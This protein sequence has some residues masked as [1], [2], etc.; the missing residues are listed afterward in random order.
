[1]QIKNIDKIAKVTK[2]VT[3]AGEA[4]RDDFLACAIFLAV[5]KRT[6]A[7][8]PAVTRVVK[9]TQQ[10]LDDPTVAVI[11]VGG[12]HDPENMNFDHHQLERDADATCALKQVLEYLGL[13]EFANRIFTWLSVS[14]VLDAKGP[15]TAARMLGTSQGVLFSMVS[16]LEG[17]LL[18]QFRLGQLNEVTLAAFGEAL[19]RDY[20]DIESDYALLQLRAKVIDVNGVKAMLFLDEK[21]I[22]HTA[23]SLYRQDKGFDVTVVKDDRGDGWTLYRYDDHKAVDFLR[24]RTDGEVTFSHP[25][26]FIAKTKTQCSEQKLVELLEK[27]IQKGA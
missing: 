2:V 8:C 9:V 24:V 15:M 6:G 26:G 3:H 22:M 19:I 23:S 27:A 4:H 17:I 1:M 18:D 5:L 21:K 25:A 11:D 12:R 14:V 13:W 16:P 7:N 10:D 20:G